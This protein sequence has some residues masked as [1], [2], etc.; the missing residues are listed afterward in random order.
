MQVTN[1]LKKIVL[2]FLLY[3]AKP[4]HLVTAKLKNYP[5]ENRDAAIR[6]ILENKLISLFEIKSNKGRNPV[7]I[8]LTDKGLLEASSLNSEPVDK[9][10]WSI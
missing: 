7:M 9:I 1:K 5:K 4:R 10:V 6:Y 3:E 2:L 8:K